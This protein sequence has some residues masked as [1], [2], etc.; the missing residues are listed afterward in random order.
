MTMIEKVARVF[1][2]AHYARQFPKGDSRDL[3]K[4][5]NNWQPFA[6]D[7]RTAIEAMR[8]PPDD[9]GHKFEMHHTGYAALWRT[10]IDAAL[11]EQP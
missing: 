2:Y 10:M 7:A 6:D 5:K 11:K 9:V 1:A 4:L 3:E 8:E